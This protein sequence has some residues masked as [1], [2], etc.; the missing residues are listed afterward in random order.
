M[1]NG[2]TQSEPVRRRGL[3]LWFAA[4]FMIVFVA[5]SLTVTILSM[6]PS[7]QYVVQMKLWEYYLAE[8]GRFSIGPRTMGPGSSS[9][10]M[11]VAAEH[12]LM[13]CLGGI[14]TLGIGW[15]VRRVRKRK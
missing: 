12:L 2:E 15:V 8:M 5:M 7:G 14:L 13:S 3:W 4:G 6:H 10:L 1:S 9:S 11:T